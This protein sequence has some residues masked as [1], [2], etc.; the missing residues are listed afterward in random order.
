MGSKTVLI[1]GAGI[2]GP[3]LAYWLVR[4][5][6]KPTIVERAPA[7]REGGYV[8]DF[9]GIGFDVAERMGIIPAL[10]QSGYV[11][12]RVVFVDE[13]GRERSAFGGDALRRALDDRFLS[14]LRS[15][16]ARILYE[17]VRNDTEFIFGNEV[18][19]VT[20][21]KKHVLVK[22]KSGILREFDMVVGADGLHSAVREAAF[23][24]ARTAEHYL[25]KYA[26]VFIGKGYSR[27]DEKTYLSYAA[28]GRQIGRFSLRNDETGFF[29]VFSRRNR[30]TAFA[31]S[32]LS[33]KK[34]LEAVFSG[35]G[36]V[37][38]PEISAQLAAAQTLYFD[39]VS[40]I[41]LPRWSRGRVALVG[42][43]AYCPSLLAGEGAAFAMAGS[44]ILA[45]E[46][47]RANG[48]V[49]AAFA[50]YE[51]VF[52]R[53]ILRKQKSARGFA[54]SFSPET[55]FGLKVR[56]IV[57]RLAANPFIADFLVWRMISDRFILPDYA[58]QP[59]ICS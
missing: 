11:N 16:L 8:I 41:Q 28:P 38:W 2:A 32:L 7:P 56:D 15:D 21:L 6:F 48:D 19:A 17:A 45:G 52:R 23:P 30:D 4:A 26:A 40:Q 12:D 58:T 29:F 5:G 18:S 55:R 54:S 43:A 35:D 34:A 27:R 57:L 47:G 22:F 46:L 20:E 14:I 37:E 10:R 9:W 24:R 50:A 13:G 39:A 42:D 36:W 44:Y 1:S 53:F 59:S 49:R 31:R 25:G 3:T 51:R 33:Q